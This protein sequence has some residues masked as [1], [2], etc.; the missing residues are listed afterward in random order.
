MHMVHRDRNQASN[1]VCR[2]MM[3]P[4]RRN[5]SALVQVQIDLH[6]RRQSIVQSY[7]ALI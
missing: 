2:H 4:S 1:M 3:I 5:E 7:W 6:R